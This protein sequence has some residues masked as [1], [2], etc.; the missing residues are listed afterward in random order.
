MIF[1][2]KVVV[3]TGASSGIGK[4]LAEE[5]AAKGANLVL[6]ARQYVTLCDI[7][8]SL[9]KQY[10]IRAVAVQCDVSDEDDC[11]LMIAQAIQ[12]FKKIDV[13]VNNAG[14]SMRA[15]F[16]DVDLKVLKQIMDINFWGTVYCTKYAMPELLKTK[17]SVVGVSSVAGY[18]GLPGR[19]GYSASKFA[20]N[21]FLDSLRVEN[22]KTGVHV[23]TACPGFTNSNIRNTALAKDGSQ[24]GETHMDEGKLMSSEEVA[25][26]IVDGVAARKRTLIMTTQGK[27]AVL[28]SKFIPAKLDE[29]VYNTFAKE[30]DALLK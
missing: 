4:A 11:K 21:G 9:E 2:D 27:L 17:G 19:T 24:Q 13:L 5:F 26:I 28:L 3:I 20:M 7:A 29:L 18:K 14:I 23:M 15:L 22:L 16:K 1:K 30:K 6:A 12:S 25:R 10:N 8:Q